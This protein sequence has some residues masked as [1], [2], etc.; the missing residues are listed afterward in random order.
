[1][2]ISKPTKITLLLLSMLTMMSNVAIVTMLPHLNEHFEDVKNIEL[3]SRL[4]I[5]LPSL[6]IALLSPFLGHFVY[7]TGKK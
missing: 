7:K 6:S 5:T 4:M 3:Y 1:M 2:S